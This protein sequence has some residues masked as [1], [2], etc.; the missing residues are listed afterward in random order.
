MPKKA[1]IR[2]AQQMQLALFTSQPPP[3]VSDLHTPSRPSVSKKERKLSPQEQDNEK[4]TGHLESLDERTPASIDGASKDRRFYSKQ[5]L[6]LETMSQLRLGSYQGTHKLLN[7]CQVSL[8]AKLHFCCRLALCWLRCNE[9]AKPMLLSPKQMF[10]AAEVLFG[11]FDE[12]ESKDIKPVLLKLPDLWRQAV[13]EQ[14]PGQTLQDLKQ[15]F[16]IEMGLAR[17]Q[18]TTTGNP[19]PCQALDILFQKAKQE[20]YKSEAPSS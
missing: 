19:H 14:F 7:E 13:L 1:K 20:L 11:K 3:S 2:P 16:L 10:E 15:Q 5:Q 6:S 18:G 4:I 17:V 12:E 9:L 8:D